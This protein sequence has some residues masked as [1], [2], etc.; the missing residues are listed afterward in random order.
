MLIR[1]LSPSTTFCNSSFA[2][3]WIP[4]DYSG[5][6][7]ALSTQ[8]YLLLD[9]PYFPF[10]RM[11]LC[12]DHKVFSTEF[13]KLLLTVKGCAMLW[14]LKWQ[15]WVRNMQSPCKS[16]HMEWITSGLR[17]GHVLCQD[18]GQKY[19]ALVLVQ[20][21]DVSKDIDRKANLKT[22]GASDCSGMEL[23]R[24]CFFVHNTGM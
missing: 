13:A 7:V 21:S 15:G 11:S 1:S 5:A 8:V 3:I 20:P 12:R 16:H 18:G 6:S 24:L 22:V 14:Y 19:L 2:F 10:R 17:I 4:T 9:I 23:E